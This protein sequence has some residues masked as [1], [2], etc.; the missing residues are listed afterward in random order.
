MRGCGT[1]LFCLLSSLGPGEAAPT[2]DKCKAG[3]T[4]PNCNQCDS[5]YYNSDSIC[6][7]CQCN[8]NV[9]PALSPSICKPESG[10][11]IGCLYHTAGFHCQECEDGYVR[12]P[13]GTNCTRKGNGRSSK[14]SRGLPCTS[15][16]SRLGRAGC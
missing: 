5:G 9:D 7:T 2:C 12:D 10:E 15:D 3:Y 16:G 4:G 13:E 6:V 1:F 14:H 8:G 11:C